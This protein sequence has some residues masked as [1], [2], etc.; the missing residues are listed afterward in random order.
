MDQTQLLIIVGLGLL[1]GLLIWKYKEGFGIGSNC[2]NGH[3]NMVDYASNMQLNPVFQEDPFSKA[4]PLSEGTPLM[5]PGLYQQMPESLTS[6]YGKEIMPYD[7][8]NGNSG[9]LDY[10]TSYNAAIPQ[11]RQ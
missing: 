1:I 11:M 7:Y 2:G 8:F 6:F 3:V 10:T 9:M 4:I 5:Y